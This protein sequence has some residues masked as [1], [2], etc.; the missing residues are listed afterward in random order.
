MSLLS[1]IVEVIQA[2]G[3]D[4]KS[5]V[6]E[7]AE[8]I[9]GSNSGGVTF[10]TA[11]IATDSGLYA[12]ITNVHIVAP[13]S[14][15]QAI[16]FAAE[17]QAVFVGA[18]S[19]TGG[20]H[21]VGSMGWA[22]QNSPAA[23]AM[24]IGVEGRFDHQGAGVTDRG[25]GILGLTTAQ[26]GKINKGYGVRS[27]LQIAS[28]AEITDGYGYEA[29][30]SQNAGTMSSYT[31]Y[32]M[33]Q[34]SGLVP[35]PSIMRFIDNREPNAP[36]VSAAPIIDQSYVV[37]AGVG[38]GFAYQILDNIGH[39]QLVPGETLATGTLQLPAN[40][41]DGQEVSIATT[42]QITALNLLGNNRTVFGGVTSLP[43]NA[44]ATYRYVGGGYNVW[45][46]KDAV[47]DVIG[48]VLTGY[49]AKTGSVAATDTILV[50]FGKLQNGLNTTNGLLG[51]KQ[52]AIAGKGLSTEDYTTAEK[53]KLAGLDSN[54]FKGTYTTPAALTSAWPGAAAGDY[55]DVDAGAGAD[56]QRY[57]WDISDNKWVLQGGSTS[58]TAAQVKTL[59]ESNSDT[60]AFS[61][62]Y[63][64]KLDAF[65][66]RAY[67]AVDLTTAAVT[68][69][70]A[71][72]GGVFVRTTTNTMTLPSL[73]T[74]T[75]GK[76]FT[77]VNRVNNGGFNVVAASGQTL[78][79]GANAAVSSLFVLPGE[80]LEVT[81]SLAGT[82]A[83]LITQRG[84]VDGRTGLTSSLTGIALN[85]PIPITAE[86]NV[87]GALGRLQA[88]FSLKVDKK[89]T[90]GLSDN[91]YSDEEK[92]AVQAMDPVGAIKF[93][94]DNP[95]PTWVPAKGGIRLRAGFR[96]LLMAVGLLGGEVGS[97]TY[98]AVTTGTS[99]AAID[100]ASCPAR[101]PM[102]KPYVMQL[103]AG[104]A[105][106]ISKDG[107]ATWAAGTATGIAA[108]TSLSYDEGRGV[109]I[110]TGNTTSATNNI[111]YSADDGVTWTAARFTTT[112]GAVT[113]GPARCMPSNDGTW[114][115]TLVAASTSVYRSTDMGQNWAPIVT[116]A[117]AAHSALSTDHQGVWCVVAAQTIR[118]SWDDGLTWEVKLAASA[119]ALTGITNDKR[120]TW[121]ASGTTAASNTY[122]SVD[123]GMNW[124]VL[125]GIGTTNVTDVVYSRDFFFFARS[126]S[127]QLV[128]ISAKADATVFVA[129]STAVLTSLN[130][131]TATEGFIVG[132]SSAAST[133]SLVCSPKYRYNSSTQFQLPW[134]SGIAEGITAWVK[135]TL[136]QVRSGRI[137]VDLAVPLAN[138]QKMAASP[139]TIIAAGSSGDVTVINRAS[140]VAYVT[141]IG[142]GNILDVTTNGQGTW[143][144]LK[145]AS[146]KFSLSTD[147]GVSFADVSTNT[148]FTIRSIAIT[149]SGAFLAA[150]LTAV[151]PARKA[152]NA[153]PWVTIPGLPAISGLFAALGEMVVFYC[154]AA[155]YVSLDGGATF[156]P[157]PTAPPLVG[158]ASSVHISP[159]G[160]IVLCSQDASTALAISLDNGATWETRS[161]GVTASAQTQVLAG[162]GG[163][164][165][166]KSANFNSYYYST[167]WGVTFQ[168]ATNYVQN[169]IYAGTKPTA[170]A[171]DQNGEFYYTGTYT[172]PATPGAALMTTGTTDLAT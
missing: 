121:M 142:A 172:D 104:G 32:Y 49:A 109:W 11:N 57:I 25:Q 28:G 41:V 158:L 152:G 83:W 128:A 167:D 86:D 81:A 54:H 114:I 148:T 127:P 141:N 17:W 3:T 2:V 12:P 123:N 170:L 156:T 163:M 97:N 169:S 112:G 166:L 168:A 80:M 23:L 52:N 136:G 94:A 149:G 135:T 132:V 21:I 98:A 106:R 95:G 61:N 47:Q 62:A 110:A 122:R 107:G 161:I 79:G 89:S 131:I 143:G 164:M 87:L 55:A 58:L 24:G 36:I 13:G 71:Q 124:V 50:A 77:F 66:Y 30:F 8:K 92:V 64:A 22:V 7:L 153:Q 20:G 155:C 67:G 115:A 165:A 19:V 130:K 151:A 99:V 144:V 108:P 27:E 88:Q 76:T 10:G 29:K 90:K 96:S 39:V 1:R 134:I 63:K 103:M 129:Q 91:N 162:R 26:H 46:R 138:A 75:D 73:G 137:M 118:R 78:L 171:T 160:A 119:A 5:V 157:T 48:A 68:L 33:P 113:T 45:F 126:I 133:T 117:S 18:G 31:G 146:S 140:Q 147:D 101:T 69:T 84:N 145:N 85:Q 116:G 159:E 125:G 14:E 37:L 150:A 4:F 56:V 16:N 120:G 100:V 72:A 51:A 93:S 102:G 53:A 38:S 15:S 40:P 6:V 82:P 70:A 42:Q 44:S 34:V 139:R 59:Y 65:S 9:D 43:A 154:Q 105:I 60:N 111:M 35:T 74:M